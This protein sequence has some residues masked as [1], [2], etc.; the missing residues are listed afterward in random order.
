MSGHSKWANIRVKKTAE[1]KKRSAIFTKMAKLILVAVKMGGGTDV[2]QNSQLKSVIDRAKQVN[3]PKDSIERVLQ[4]FDKGGSNLANYLLEGFA[5]GGIYLITEVETDNKI[6]T[7]NQ[8]RLILEKHGGGLGSNNSAMHLFDRMGR[9]EIEGQ[10]ND[11]LW[12]KLVEMGALDIVDNLVYVHFEDLGKFMLGLH[13]DKVDIA[14]SGLY[15]RARAKIGADK[16]TIGQI[17]NMIEDISEI[18]EV[19]DVFTNLD[20][21]G[22]KKD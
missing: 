8:V 5:P 4:K 6:R 19:V 1:D 13:N 18:D 10:I 21:Q 20:D 17:E 7:A 22:A 3:M 2:N 16:T 9:I 15:L 14:D 12:E 11:Q